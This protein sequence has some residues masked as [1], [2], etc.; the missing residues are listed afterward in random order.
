MIAHVAKL[1]N[2]ERGHQVGQMRLVYQNA[3]S[4]IVWLG[5]SNSEVDHL[6]DVMRQL[7]NHVLTTNRPHT[8][9]TWETQWTLLRW[10]SPGK[11]HHRGF[12]NALRQMLRREWFTRI[13]VLQ[14]VAVAKSAI[15][16]CGQN[17]VS[18]RTFVM[19]P[20]LL[21]IARDVGERARLEIMPGPLRR[22]SWWAEDST[23]DLLT[24]LKK[25][26]KSNA[27]DQRDR[28]YALLGL[29]TDAYNSDILRPNYEISLSETIQHCVA[30]LLMKTKDLPSQTPVQQL[31][32]W[33][34]DD[35]LEAL[36]DLPSEVFKWAVDHA[37]EVL[38]T[39]FLIAQ[40]GKKDPQLMHNLMDYKGCQGSAFMVA[41][42]QANVVL[43]DLLLPWVSEDVA[44]R[45]EKGNTL[46]MVAAKAGG[47]DVLGLMLRFWGVDILPGRTWMR[48]QL[49]TA[50]GLGDLASVEV[51]L[52]ALRTDDFW[53]DR[54]F[55]G[56]LNLATR[57]GDMNMVHLFLRR[58]KAQNP[59][60]VA[61][62]DF[63]GFKILETAIAGGFSMIVKMLLGYE[64][65]ATHHAAHNAVLSKQ[66][67]ILDRILDLDPH[68]VNRN[69]P[70]IPN[71]LQTAS[72]TGDRKIIELLLH[73]GAIADPEGPYAEMVTTVDEM[74][75]D[76]WTL[77]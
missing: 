16:T 76:L 60:A 19:M 70:D 46:L 29:S 69:A 55:N 36:K 51:S 52:N 67:D 57:R 65:R 40:K 10:R 38:L 5:P 73:R 68:L 12:Q 54:N 2:Q 23:A 1:L 28:I 34:V 63:E 35:F 24:L 58:F 45:D 62:K 59:E 48:T 15:I 43:M 25:F 14:E 71:L 30:Y 50:I 22:T 18:S 8:R 41:I 4:V 26:G 31:P 3:E 42:K 37:N 7:D 32:K 53:N 17:K 20:S 9:D 33:G 75:T 21:V 39:N 64:P 66:P 72:G 11:Y 56:M 47:H 61:F 49:F 13:W 6:F 27:S 77:G 44:K 74:A